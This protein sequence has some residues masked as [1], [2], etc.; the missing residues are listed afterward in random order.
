MSSLVLHCL[1]QLRN[2]ALQAFDF[3]ARFCLKE[4]H[5]GVEFAELLALALLLTPHLPDRLALNLL[6]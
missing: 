1:R 3:S 6:D 2:F 4:G 5:L